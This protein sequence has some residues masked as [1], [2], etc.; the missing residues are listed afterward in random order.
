MNAHGLAQFE[1]ERLAA[2]GE[3]ACRN[4]EASRF[5]NGREL[6]RDALVRNRIG[7]AE[8]NEVVAAISKTSHGRSSLRMI[9]TPF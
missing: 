6:A 9:A 7:A 5:E 2:F 3:D 8:E 1:N 4:G